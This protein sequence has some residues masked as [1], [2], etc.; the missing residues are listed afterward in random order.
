MSEQDHEVI[1][2]EKKKRMDDTKRLEDQIKLE[3]E[4][5]SFFSYLSTFVNR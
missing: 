2:E 4:R 3:K 1:R 5:K